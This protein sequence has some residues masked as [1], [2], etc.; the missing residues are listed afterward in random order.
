MWIRAR[1]YEHEREKAQQEL[2]LKSM[3][4][5]LAAAVINADRGDYEPARQMAGDFFTSVRSQIERGSSSDLSAAQR[6]KVKMLMRQRDE[7]I[8]LLARSD[9]AAADRLSDLY[10][11]YR[12]AM[13]DVGPSASKDIAI[14]TFHMALHKKSQ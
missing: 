11:A 6:D 4:G 2:R 5:T 9:P 3:E 8:T 13:N 7:L 14:D 1:Q 10:I 12:R